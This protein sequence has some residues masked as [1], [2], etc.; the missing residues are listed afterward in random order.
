MGSIGGMVGL[1]RAMGVEFDGRGERGYR[2][3]SRK[4][5]SD[6]F[7]FGGLR[8]SGGGMWNGVMNVVEDFL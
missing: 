7:G 1:A 4:S 8:W 3:R 2:K 6:G 5:G